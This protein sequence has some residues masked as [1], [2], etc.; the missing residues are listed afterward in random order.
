[1]DDVTREAITWEIRHGYRGTTPRALQESAA[2]IGDIPLPGGGSVRLVNGKIVENRT[3]TKQ[4]ALEKVAREAALLEAAG[5]PESRTK[6]RDVDGRSSA[7]VALLRAGAK[8]RGLTPTQEEQE[9]P[10]GQVVLL[11]E[12]KEDH[13]DHVKLAE[14]VTRGSYVPAPKAGTHQR[15]LNAIRR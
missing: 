6:D 3:P 1:M 11:R 12:I 4:A 15:L 5:E 13:S 7:F 8:R 14:A 2:G 10:N 9:V